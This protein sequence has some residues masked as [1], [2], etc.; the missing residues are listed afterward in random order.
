MSY[1]SRHRREAPA[2]PLAKPLPAKP[3][4][5]PDCIPPPPSVTHYPMPEGTNGE[6]D[7]LRRSTEGEDGFLA[8]ARLAGVGVA[9]AVPLSASQLAGLARRSLLR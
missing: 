3:R 9:A 4:L 6:D 8:K 5:Y 2:V 1:A 7:D